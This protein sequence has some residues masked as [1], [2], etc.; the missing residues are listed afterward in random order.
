VPSHDVH[1]EVEELDEIEYADL[2]EDKDDIEQL[3][4]LSSFAGSAASSD[5]EQEPNGSERSVRNSPVPF[6]HH[7]TDDEDDDDDVAS[8]TADH[9]KTEP[10]RS[11]RPSALGQYVDKDLSDVGSNLG[12]QEMGEQPAGIERHSPV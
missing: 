9:I 6:E 3:E 10:A 11:E 1:H 4:T 5:D 2:P 8:T 12:S 7:A